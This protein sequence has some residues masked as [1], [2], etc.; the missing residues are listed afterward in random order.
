MQTEVIGSKLALH[1]PPGVKD[2]YQDMLLGHY[3]LPSDNAVNSLMEQFF[4]ASPLTK[5]TDNQEKLLRFHIKDQCNYFFNREL[6]KSLAEEVVYFTAGEDSYPRRILYLNEI[7]VEKAKKR[8]LAVLSPQEKEEL[9]TNPIIWNELHHRAENPSGGGYAGRVIG[10][11][12]RPLICRFGD[13]Y[14]FTH[15]SY[16]DFLDNIRKTQG[17][18][19][20]DLL[21]GSDIGGSTGLAAH[22]AE[23]LDPYTIIT[24]TTTDPEI[25]A[26]PLRGG[27]RFLLAERL[28]E[29]FFEKFD[30]I[31]SNYAFCYTV[32]PGIALMN[33][34]FSLKVG[35][36]FWI[37][38]DFDRSP[39]FRQGTYDV[40][41]NEVANVYKYLSD[42]KD[43]GSV[44][45]L[46]PFYGKNDDGR[47]IGERIYLQ[48]MTNI[49]PD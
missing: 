3:P 42:L 43:K 39:L 40:V 47:L 36:P 11:G 18:N 5:I 30:F 15:T 33:A 4:K 26:W 35:G 45:F 44:R 21:N 16:Q 13:G 32:F 25:G 9:F 22:Q 2:F 23:E 19:E 1:F 10:Y 31:V 46:H 48:K 37:N 24:N 29:D 41:F 28:P 17:K 14:G 27:H 34:L 7:S 38:F 49:Y 20:S 6:F 8:G 12:T